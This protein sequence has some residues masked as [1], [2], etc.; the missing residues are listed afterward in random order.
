[1]HDWGKYWIIFFLAFEIDLDFKQTN[2]W[3]YL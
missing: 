1:M 3:K 2:V